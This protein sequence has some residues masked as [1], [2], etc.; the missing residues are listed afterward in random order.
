MKTRKRKKIRE[1]VNTSMLREMTQKLAY[2]NGILDSSPNVI[3]V[4]N[5]KNEIIMISKRSEQL[6]GYRKKELLGKKFSKILKRNRESWDFM[7]MINKD[8]KIDEYPVTLLTCKGYEIPFSAAVSKLINDEQEEIGHVV[9][10]HDIHRRVA[11]EKQLRRQYAEL[12]SIFSNS[13]AM[14]V[15]TNPKGKITKINPSAERVLGVKNN[16]MIGQTMT[17]YYVDKKLRRKMVEQLKVNESIEFEADIQTADGEIR[18]FFVVLSNIRSP[19]THKLLGTV[20]ISHDITLRK[21]TENK[22]KKM[23]ITDSLTGIGNRRFFFD[24]LKVF[25]RE[26]TKSPKEHFFLC[27]LDFD[28]FKSYNDSFGHQKGDDLLYDFGQLCHSFKSKRRSPLFFRYGGDEFV[29]L[30]P[31]NNLEKVHRLL[32]KLRLTFS[33]ITRKHVTL[34][35]GATAYR[36]RDT[37]EKIIYRADRAVYK[38]KHSGRNCIQLDIN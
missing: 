26:A 37:V 7:A 16:D 2:L 3:L 1:H 14:I 9:N 18:T 33:K 13:R 25:L 22:L 24:K 27:F 11:L 36:R 29:C 12:D 28:G 10:L 20:G 5:L 38:A 8:D 32:N 4:L 34:S 19:L 21:Q 23:L 31:G 35:I 6:L 30:L 17:D 15:T